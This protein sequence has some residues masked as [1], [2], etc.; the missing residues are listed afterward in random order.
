MKRKEPLLNM[1]LELEP[2]LFARGLKN[3]NSTRR[4]IPLHRRI[5]GS[6]GVQLVILALL[7]GGFAWLWIS[8][9][10]GPQMIRDRFGLWGAV[11]LMGLQALISITPMADEVIGLASS[12]IYGF[13]LG[14]LL[15]WTS[16][17][18]ANFIEYWLARRTARDL[19][20]DPDPTANRLPRRLAGLAPSHP[21]YLLLG[22]QVP[23]GCHIVN[24]SAGAYRVPIW[25]FTWTAALGTIPGSL[26]IA[27]IANGLVSWAS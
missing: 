17:M 1:N 25:R 22:R 19:G 15:N 8:T 10:G 11:L 21:L 14:S 5:A 7:V 2:H 16:W 13:A 23:L 3:S 24:A 4:Q 18:L 12:A 6:R 27:A 20:F 26:T 9:N